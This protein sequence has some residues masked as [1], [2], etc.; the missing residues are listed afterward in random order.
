LSIE[1]VEERV[2]NKNIMSTLV[3]QP[4]ELADRMKTRIYPD[5]D[6]NDHMTL[7]YYFTLLSGVKDVNQGGITAENHLK[8]L[9][10]IKGVAEG[11]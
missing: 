9:K 8:L 2:K 1:E 5:L 6:G 10:K 3:S 7:I 11:K 4:Q